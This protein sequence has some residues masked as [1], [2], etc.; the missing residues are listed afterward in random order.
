MLMDILEEE[1]CF[2][3]YEQGYLQKREG[4]YI[5]YEKNLAMQE[6]MICKREEEQKLLEEQKAAK[7][8]ESSIQKSAVLR[9]PVFALPL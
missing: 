2:F 5:Y 4:Y 7:V 9:F 8:M 6:Y 3:V 1:E